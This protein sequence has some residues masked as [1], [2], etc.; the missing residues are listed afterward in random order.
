MIQLSLTR[1]MVPSAVTISNAKMVSCISP[2]MC[3]FVSC[4]RSS[5]IRSVVDHFPKSSVPPEYHL[6]SIKRL[7]RFGVSGLGSRV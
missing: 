7:K 3:E 2:K 6:R 5:G 4:V 1:M